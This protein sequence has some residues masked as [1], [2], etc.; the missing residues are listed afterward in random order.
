MKLVAKFAFL[1]VVGLSLGH[2]INFA[3]P[4][5]NLALLI[6]PFAAMIVL[7]LLGLSD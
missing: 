3:V 6:V 5:K 4:N 2:V 1:V 7:D